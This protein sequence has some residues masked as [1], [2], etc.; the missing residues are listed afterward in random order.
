MLL[1]AYTIV[2]GLFAFW[3][4]SLAQPRY[5]ANPGLAAYEPPPATVID[6]TMPAPVLVRHQEAPPAVEIESRSEQAK[7]TVAAPTGDSTKVVERQP[8]RIIDVKKPRR[9]KAAGA[10]RERNNPLNDYAA[11]HSGYS[12][13]AAYPGYSGGRPY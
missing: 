9:P 2:F 3:F 4:Y 7:T 1:A 6:Y 10:P 5:A 13:A 11:A 8:E 12:G